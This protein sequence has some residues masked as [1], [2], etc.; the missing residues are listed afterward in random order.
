M[1]LVAEKMPPPALGWGKEFNKL[2]ISITKNT[3]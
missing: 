1:D 2:L 3:T